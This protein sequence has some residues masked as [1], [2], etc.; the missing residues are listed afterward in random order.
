MRKK[1]IDNKELIN[2][3]ADKIDVISDYIETVIDD[4]IE[5]KE[6][7]NRIGIIAGEIID[8]INRYIDGDDSVADTDDIDNTPVDDT[9]DEFDD[10]D[11]SNDSD[12]DFDSDETEDDSDDDFDN[13]SEEDDE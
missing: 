6:R 13:D 4:R 11:T 10:T 7:L 5:N 3:L 1:D 9:S 2:E 12:D 8:L